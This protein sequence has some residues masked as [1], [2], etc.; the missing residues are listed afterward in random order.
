MPTYNNKGTIITK[1]PQTSAGTMTIQPPDHDKNDPYYPPTKN[2]ASATFLYT[3]APVGALVAFDWEP[4]P[5]GGYYSI[6]LP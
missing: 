5:Q 2:Q 6:H 1:N 4:L 3:T